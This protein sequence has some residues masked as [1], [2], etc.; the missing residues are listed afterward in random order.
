MHS[1]DMLGG[2]LTG[3]DLA[4]GS[5]TGGDLANNTL[6]GAKIADGSIY[7][8]DVGS[9]GLSGADILESS[10]VGVYSASHAGDVNGVQVQRIEFIVPTGIAETQVLSAGC[11]TF[12]TG[13]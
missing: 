4:D 1:T 6:P 9:N 2:S 7:G 12:R 8:A 13:G 11:R 5:L 10:L 3:G